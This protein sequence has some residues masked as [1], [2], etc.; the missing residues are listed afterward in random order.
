VA[1]D[2]HTYLV[3]RLGVVGVQLAEQGADGVGLA[4]RVVEH[5][6]ADEVAEHLGQR[7]SEGAGEEKGGARKSEVGRRWREGI[8]PSE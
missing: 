2:G 3:A 1:D 8:P 6:L 4:F 7:G 5:V